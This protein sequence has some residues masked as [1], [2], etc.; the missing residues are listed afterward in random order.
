M[1]SEIAMKWTKVLKTGAVEVK[2]MG[3][4]LN[5]IMFTMVKGQ[6]TLEVPLSFSLD[7]SGFTTPQRLAI[8]LITEQFGLEL[9][10]F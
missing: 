6:D 3:I 4:D 7:K 9:I 8:N 5:T 1:V 2:F 10:C